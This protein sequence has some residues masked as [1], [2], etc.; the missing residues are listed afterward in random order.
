[1]FVHNSPG[2]STVCQ[3]MLHIPGRNTDFCWMPLWEE[4]PFFLFLIKKES[5][6]AVGI[7]GGE[8]GLP[9]A[10]DNVFGHWNFPSVPLPYQRCTDMDGEG[11]FVLLACP[12]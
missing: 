1:M 2:D 10:W 12:G 9:G 4:M 5:E 11:S 3:D 6:W 7:G 8:M